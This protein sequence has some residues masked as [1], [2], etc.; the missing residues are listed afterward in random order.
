MARS[1]SYIEL[2]K[3]V[4][5]PEVTARHGEGRPQ[6][7]ARMQ[8]VMPIQ[9]VVCDSDEPIKARHS[10]PNG[11]AFTPMK[12]QPKHHGGAT[13]PKPPKWDDPRRLALRPEYHAA[14]HGASQNC[15]AKELQPQYGPDYLLRD[16]W[17]AEGNG[18]E[19][20]VTKTSQGR[21]VFEMQ[22]VVD[23]LVGHAYNEH[24]TL[25]YRSLW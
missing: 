25:V 20:G 4:S 13:L 17:S 6:G 19:S 1:Q 22:Y 16:V 9:E 10:P 24:G 7:T 18:A 11:T 14:E 8:Q 12:V 2:R 15:T 5:S 23:R 3:I 21:K